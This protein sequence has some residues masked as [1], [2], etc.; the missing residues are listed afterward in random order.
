MTTDEVCR[1]KYISTLSIRLSVLKSTSR[2]Q[3][4][5]NGGYRHN[6]LLTRAH[7]TRLITMVLRNMRETHIPQNHSY[8]A[9]DYPASEVEAGLAIVARPVRY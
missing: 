3:I 4:G 9:R 5:T 7:G 1:F 2:R 8:E 6:I